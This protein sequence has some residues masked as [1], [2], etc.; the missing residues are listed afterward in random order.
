MRNLYSI[1]FK[2]V[3]DVTINIRISFRRSLQNKNIKIFIIDRLQENHTKFE[4]VW[5]LQNSLSF[6][7]N[8][9]AILSTYLRI[10]KLL[11][12]N[13]TYWTDASS[14]KFLGAYLKFYVLRATHQG[15]THE[16][17]ACHF[18]HLTANFAGA[19][20]AW[21]ISASPGLMQLLQFIMKLNKVGATLF[22]PHEIYTPL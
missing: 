11:N 6:V 9:I 21:F 1:I 2:H 8:F 16:A 3:N 15:I 17:I 20:I 19:G 4:L 13:N 5:T 22:P 10:S 12:Q 18:Y 14:Y 7:N